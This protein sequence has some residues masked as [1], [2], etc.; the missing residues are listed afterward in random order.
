MAQVVYRDANFG[1]G[2]IR[3]DCGKLAA[4]ALRVT[5]LVPFFMPWESPKLKMYMHVKT[6]SIREYA[7]AANVEAYGSWPLLQASYFFARRT[8]VVQALLQQVLE[9]LTRRTEL[10]AATPNPSP[11]KSFRWNCGDQVH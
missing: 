1:R 4:I 10:V 3:E 9:I 11:H 6:Y 2:Y 7:G 5:E 8:P